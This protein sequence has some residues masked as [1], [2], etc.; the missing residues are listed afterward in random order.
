MEE[1]WQKMASWMAIKHGS[2]GMWIGF[3]KNVFRD[4][5]SRALVNSYFQVSELLKW[6][7]NI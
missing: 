2:H 4:N 5:P 3:Q 6:D 1:P 7:L